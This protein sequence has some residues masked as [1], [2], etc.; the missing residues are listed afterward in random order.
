MHRI[1]SQGRFTKENIG[2]QYLCLFLFCTYC[3]VSHLHLKMLLF[4]HRRRDTEILDSNSEIHMGALS[5]LML[6]SILNFLPHPLPIS[7]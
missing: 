6:E 1:K 3:L 7:I 5:T 4:T 2:I